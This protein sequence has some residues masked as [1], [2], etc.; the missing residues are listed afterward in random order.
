A[1]TVS[2]GQIGNALGHVVDRAI[3]R[4]DLD[5]RLLV[6]RPQAPFALAGEQCGRT[7]VAVERD[8][9]R[10]PGATLIRVA[11]ELD[12]MVALDAFGDVVD[13]RDRGFEVPTC[14]RAERAVWILRHRDEATDECNRAELAG[15]VIDDV[16]G[17]ARARG[18][19]RVSLQAG[20]VVK[21]VVVVGD[22]LR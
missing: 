18:G 17:D 16:N 14:D 19:K 7:D 12:A 15:D 3:R 8:V 21:R 22:V 13:V 4:V 11:G 10:G 5:P 9:I 2:A 6:E 20:P 1:Q